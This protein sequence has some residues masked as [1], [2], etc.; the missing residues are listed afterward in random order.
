MVAFVLLSPA[1][2]PEFATTLSITR[3]SASNRTSS[4][5]LLLSVPENDAFAVVM[6][7][8]Y[9]A[10]FIENLPAADGNY[11]GRY[12]FELNPFMLGALRVSHPCDFIHDNGILR[13]RRVTWRTEHRLEFFRSRL[14]CRRNYGGR[15]WF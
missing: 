14:C 13:R 3:H 4:S 12:V 11:R 8:F 10:A 15:F 7:D 9:T 2:H 1:G 6:H 5:S